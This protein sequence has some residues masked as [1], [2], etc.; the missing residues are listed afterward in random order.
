MKK[1]EVFQ[2]VLDVYKEL[3]DQVVESGISVDVFRVMFM[4]GLSSKFGYSF[5]EVEK[6]VEVLEN[7]VSERGEGNIN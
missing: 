1:I 3:R 7:F 4:A 2:K 5:E 6:I